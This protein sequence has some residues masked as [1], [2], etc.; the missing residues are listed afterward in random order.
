[1][2]HKVEGNKI[3]KIICKELLKDNIS[4]TFILA[5]IIII[6]IIVKALEYKIKKLEQII[7]S[8]ATVS[9]LKE[10]IF[11]IWIYHIIVTLL[12]EIKTPIFTRII[13]TFQTRISIKAFRSLID[14]HWVDSRNMKNGKIQYC[15]D[16]GSRATGKIINILLLD[17][18]PQIITQLISF[19]AIGVN[20]GKE[21]IGFIAVYL[22]CCVGLN[23]WISNQR[24]KYKS[25]YNECKIHVDKFLY[26]SLH[27]LD[28]I[29]VYQSANHEEDKYRRNLNLLQKNILYFKTL[30][31][32]FEL[33]FLIISISFKT[34][35]YYY[36]LINTDGNEVSCNL[37][38]LSVLVGLI[39]KSSAMSGNIYKKIKISILNCQSIIKYL[40]AEKEYFKNRDLI[41]QKTVELKNICFVAGNR[42]IIENI[43][44]TI[45]KGE[46]IAII[47]E[48]GTGKT[49][50]LKIIT[51]LYD[52]I[53]DI[54]IDGI[55]TNN[56]ER[57]NILQLFSYIGQDPLIYDDSIYY[58][59]I[60]GNWGLSQA[61][62][63]EV[64]KM[65]GLHDSIME[66][67]GNYKYRA[68]ENG[69]RLS[70]GQRKKITIARAILNNRDVILVD[71]P[72]RFL[73]QKSYK[74][75]IDILINKLES[76]TI[77]IATYD[78]KVIK[79]FNRIF[80]LKNG[81][82]I[83]INNKYELEPS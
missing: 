71:D 82:L 28:N 39:E 48:N 45:K 61:K 69:C 31:S 19:C 17:L 50:L 16:N 72:C 27:N 10:T 24:L 2:E 25:R 26:E 51:G 53:G 62:I 23:Y 55:L 33:I 38:Q 52:Y 67:E 57:E 58:N 18:F 80:Q 3:I 43:N 29:L 47:G 68:G 30:G 46:K 40:E 64:S 7:G 22:I 77:I 8:N 78:L 59:L 15:I 5:V 9:K 36:Y 42:R 76:K 70:S 44:L 63:I 66:L 83:E 56:I 1:M 75:F 54:I 32:I 41:F 79:Y 13:G 20:F 14:L 12:W 49:T 34:S 65:V 6:I 37:R 4:V 35:I 81:M 74:I 60:Y 73:D 11:I 21:Y